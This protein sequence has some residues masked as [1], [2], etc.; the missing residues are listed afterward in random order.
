MAP[1]GLKLMETYYM[2]RGILGF[3][4]IPVE[5]HWSINDIVTSKNSS[6]KRDV[7]IKIVHD[8]FE[9]FTDEGNVV[10]SYLS[11]LFPSC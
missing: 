1:D 6:S 2:F 5:E 3:C 7:C 10:V 4:G 9:N 11:L 8:S